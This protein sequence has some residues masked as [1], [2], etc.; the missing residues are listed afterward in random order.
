VALSDGTPGLLPELAG[1]GVSEL[2]I[3]GAPPADPVRAT[4]WVAD[5]AAR[6]MPG[7]RDR[8]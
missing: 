2:V 5:L 7:S 4:A 6:W 3:V 1:S 8:G